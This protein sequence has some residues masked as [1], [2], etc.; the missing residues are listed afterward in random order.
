MMKA[1]RGEIFKTSRMA[2]RWNDAYLFVGH[3]RDGGFVLI[4]LLSHREI[5]WWSV[6]NLQRFSVDGVLY[7]KTFEE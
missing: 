6:D 7:E 2:G 5:M 1:Y 4:K 3:H